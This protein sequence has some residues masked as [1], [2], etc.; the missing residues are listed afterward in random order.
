MR[1]RDQQDA[2]RGQPTAQRVSSTSNYPPQ[3]TLNPHRPSRVNALPPPCIFY[4]GCASPSP[5]CWP[6]EAPQTAPSIRRWPWVTA[7]TPPRRYGRPPDSSH[8]GPVGSRQAPLP[9]RPAQRACP[10]GFLH[11]TGSR[12]IRRSKLGAEPCLPRHLNAGGFR[13]AY[14][15][16]CRADG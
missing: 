10:N 15:L 14:D 6:S 4:S 13:H 2:A 7:A 1:R 5:S 8:N 12:G 3:Q 9:Q 11:Q 16:D